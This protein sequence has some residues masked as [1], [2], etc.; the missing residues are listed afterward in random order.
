LTLNLC[1]FSASNCHIKIKLQL[2]EK[3][4]SFEEELVWTVHSDA[5]LVD[6]SPM[7]KVPFLDTPGGPIS[8]SMAC[9]VYIEQA[10]NECPL[11]PHDAYAASKVRELTIYMALHIERVARQLYPEALSGGKMSARP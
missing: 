7:G 3:G 4:V 6:R 8:E 11:L 1:G 2:L 9:A 10:Y 5:V